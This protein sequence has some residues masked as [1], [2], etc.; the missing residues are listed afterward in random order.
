M[1][2]QITGAQPTD[3][4]WRVIHHPTGHHAR[5]MAVAGSGKTSTMVHRIGH[6]VCD[7]G[8]NPDSILV[9]MYNTLAR[10]DFQRKLAESDIPDHLVLKKVHTF[11]SFASSV[12]HRMVRD[13][14]RPNTKLWDGGQNKYWLM[15]TLRD[16]GY[17]ESIDPDLALNAI[18]LWKGSLIPPQR[19]GFIGDSRIPE[20]YGRF[21]E[22]RAQQ[23]ATTFDDWVPIVVDAFERHPEIRRW[24]CN[25]YDI[26][27]VDEYQ[28][29]NYGQE[30][31]VELAAGERADVMVVG[32]DDQTIYEWRGARPQYILEDFERNFPNKPV[33]RYDLNYTFRFGPVLAQAAFNSISQNRHR[34]DKRLI[35]R[36]PFGDTQVVVI[37]DNASSAIDVDHA[38]AEEILTLR[39]EHGVE[40]E[41]IVVL[42]RMM[43][44]LSGLEVEFLRRKIPY[45][46][47]DAEPF[48]ERS[49]IKALLAYLP[50]AARFDSM[51]NREAA[52]DLVAIVN[53]PNRA[54]SR[55]KFER[56]V[57]ANTGIRTVQETLEA[58]I[59]PDS[60][61]FSKTQCRAIQELLDTLE[62]LHEIV[63][64]PGGLRAGPA[65]ALLVEMVDYGRRLQE[66][67][68]DGE[69]AADRMLGIDH[70]IGYAG[71]TGL[72]PLA[73]V[74]HVAALDPTQ[75]QPDDQLIMMT[76]IFKTKGLEFDYVVIPHCEEGY[77]PCLY[78]RDQQVFDT[79]GIVTE[80]AL[81]APID[82][83]RRL[84]YVGAT[85]ARKVLYIGYSERPRSG[86]VRTD[87]MPSRFL[88]EAR[89]DAVREVF[90]SLQRYARGDSR[91]TGAVSSVIGKWTGQD[92]VSELLPG[93]YAR[94]MKSPSLLRIVDSAIKDAVAQPFAYGRTYR[95][96]RSSSTPGESKPEPASLV[97][98][99]PAGKAVTPQTRYRRRR[100]GA[101]E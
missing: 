54:I 34:A 37:S 95:E 51:L 58:M 38:L 10:G 74:A 25:C 52:A 84:F 24:F 90:D 76:T 56:A 49:D 16:L 31:M 92:W 98:P 44:Q 53:R 46:V 27:I 35:A 85:R 62:R 11:H 73:F 68:G 77:M 71:E 30:T 55:E 96:R 60:S 67:Y 15:R 26:V 18:S 33:I 2:Y 32:D 17:A 66:F 36:D 91:D 72:D 19:A 50:L 100:R 78:G 28:D 5:V 1:S 43:V 70:L 47:L 20:V 82:N 79:A 87:A 6:L 29:I 86:V 63:T 94:R 41:R 83:E 57:A 21:E 4:Q 64:D 61:I 59:D 48:F 12:M 69:A 39:H 80:P 45:F 88:E 97:A 65:L 14:L 22:L 99:S 89:L 9:L 40:A 7:L 13:G 93:A 81:S 8:M 42:A 101:E 3:E 75:G 23:N